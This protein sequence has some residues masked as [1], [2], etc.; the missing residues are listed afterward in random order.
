MKYHKIEIDEPFEFEAGGRLDRLELVYHTSDRE[1]RPGET[2]VWICHALTGNS[3]PEDWWPQTVGKGRLF[4]PDKY[5]IVCAGMLC[6]PYGSSSP[7]SVNP[8]TGR[9]YMMDFPKTTVRDVVRANILVRKH[10]GIEHI[11]LMIG[12]SIGGFQA[13]EW[14][15][16]EPDMV[17]DAVF[18]ATST[19]VTPYMTAFNESQRMALEADPEFMTAESLDSGKAG[20]ACARSIALISYRTFEGYNRTQQ[21]PDKE[22]LFAGRA[23]S[24]QRYQGKKMVDRFDAYCYWYLTWMLDSQNVGRGRGGVEAALAQIQADCLVVSIDS[25]VLF[26]PAHGKATVAEL[27]HARYAEIS[28]AFGHDGFLI[29]NDQLVGILQPLLDKLDKYDR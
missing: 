1:Y 7:A 8:A 17:S 5:Y 19:R 29:E 27:R 23:C 13:L 25:D 15:I 3:N 24:Y 14:V 10:L 6:S 18:L 9:P 11:D 26:P 12:P 21:E 16:M 2:V 22:T 20:L 4:D 28:S